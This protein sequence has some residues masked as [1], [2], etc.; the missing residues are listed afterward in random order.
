MSTLTARSR[1]NYFRVKDVAAFKTDLARYGLTL[2]GWD[3]S[4]D[5][6]CDESGDTL[7]L[8]A[9]DRWPDM[10]HDGLIA[11][12][13]TLEDA[14]AFAMLR[15]N[16]RLTV[17]PSDSDALARA[18]EDLTPEDFTIPDT[19]LVAFVG[20]HLVETDVAVFQTIAYDAMRS[21][22]AQATAVNARG[23]QRFVSL[24]MIY[25]FAKEIATDGT[26]VTVAHL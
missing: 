5:L 9:Y 6:I 17:D 7:A 3:G 16:T 23:E 13:E 25:D 24:D 11:H 18:I 14:E 22:D 26:P 1:T 21:F 15:D 20:E 2:G 12:I 8:F 4:S 10:S 19:D